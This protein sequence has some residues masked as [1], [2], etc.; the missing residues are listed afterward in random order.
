MTKGDHVSS[1]IGARPTVGF[2]GLG[3]MGVPM[4]RRLLATGHA[5]VGTN[6]SRAPVDTLAAEG[7]E[8]AGDAREVGERSDVILTALPTEDSVEQV[9][10]HLIE[11]GR[12]G[13]VLVE[14]STISPGLSRIVAEQAHSRGMEYL[15]APL[16]GGPAGAE[17]GSLT[18]M[19]GGDA[20]ALARVEPVLSSYGDPIHRCGK[21][22]TGQ[23]VKLVNQLLVGIHTVAAA[24]AASLGTQLGA[25]LATIL[26]VLGV[27][28]GGST[29]LTRNLPRFDQ[30]DF[31]SA[32]PVS[33][34]LKDLRLIRN[35]AGRTQV[36]LPL[37]AAAEQLMIETAA[38][39][40]ASDDMAAVVR[41]WDTPA[42]D[43]R[44]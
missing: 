27:S 39:G 14:H 1:D 10:Q 28:Y 34:I 19:V 40:H 20:A 32:T 23:V 11:V 37:G 9:A 15:D 26:E 31:S 4:V 8:P 33:L 38:Q 21:V 3:R 43:E 13:Q 42:T 22:G 7:M 29:M 18:V 44:G 12:E 24:E 25:D 35:E 16:S 30:R 2:V 17:T 41:L 6:R 5:V 36:P